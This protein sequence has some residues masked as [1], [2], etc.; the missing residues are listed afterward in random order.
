VSDAR[1]N[2]GQLLLSGFRWFDR[3]LLTR[4][5]EAGWPVLR[6]SHS[7]VMAHMNA[8]GV[9][10]SDLARKLGVTRQ[11]VHETIKDL[12]AF[13]LIE[14]APDPSD[15][16]AVIARLT[17]KGRANVQAAKDTF[18]ELEVE[19]AKRIGRKR[20]DALREALE[21]DWGPPAVAA[22]SRA[23]ARDRVRR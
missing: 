12:V 1:S 19:L 21:A 3:S 14:L 20:T 23:R 11:S 16:R 6:H 22:P 13:G 2:L 8:E 7:M 5:A 15:A 10:P 4:L 17:R 9:R 18:A